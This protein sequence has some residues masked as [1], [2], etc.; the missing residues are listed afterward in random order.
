LVEGEKKTI[1]LTDKICEI[2]G[3]N[4]TYTARSQGTGVQERLFCCQEPQWAQI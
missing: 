4:N 3:S 2:R 1:L